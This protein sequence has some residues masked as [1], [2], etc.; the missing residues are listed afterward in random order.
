[1]MRSF[2]TLMGLLLSFHFTWAARM[3]DQ[4][5]YAI[6]NPAAQNYI[7]VQGA[8]GQA[9]TSLNE[10]ART[11]TGMNNVLHNI[12]VQKS[13][14]NTTGMQQSLTQAQSLAATIKSTAALWATY[15][16]KY[17]DYIQSLQPVLEDERCRTEK[18][19]SNRCSQ[20][21]G[22]IRQTQEQR[23]QSEALYNREMAKID[24]RE[25]NQVL[26]M[27][28]PNAAASIQAQAARS[29]GRPKAPPVIKP[30]GT[31]PSTAGAVAPG[32]NAAAPTGVCK[33]EQSPNIYFS[34]TCSSQ[35]FCMGYVKCGTAATERV[36]CPYKAG[37]Y[38][39]P[40]SA[41]AC[42]AKSK[43]NAVSFIARAGK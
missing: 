10:V 9:V 3:T 22:L 1:M 32:P 28:S 33:W 14:N 2:I 42:K 13:V 12:E 37:N 4:Q 31:R 36:I 17:N 5:F 19:R 11:F 27:K 38:S 16:K 15:T 34:K 39:C 43:A 7:A 40:E 25:V 30:P 20:I 29:A 41:D 24:M 23:Q 21:E 8:K 35:R 18:N 6:A 26:A